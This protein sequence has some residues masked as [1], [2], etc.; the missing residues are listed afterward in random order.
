LQNLKVLIKSR[1]KRNIVQS[2]VYKAPL[3]TLG[4][5]LFKKAEQS[6]CVALSTLVA[7]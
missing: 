7:T 1:N 6:Y 4:G 5:T 3:G 2:P